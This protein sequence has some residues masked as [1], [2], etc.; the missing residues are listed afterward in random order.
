MRMK[1]DE[2]RFK[3][4]KLKRLN[5]GGIHVEFETKRVEEN[6]TFYDNEKLDS[7]REPHEDFLSKIRA[8]KSYLCE[9]FG[10]T[11][12]KTI[13]KHEDFKATKA[14]IKSAE[15]G[16]QNKIANIEI[17]GFSIHG[18]DDNKNVIIN[19]KFGIQKLGVVALNTPRIKFSNN[20]YG[21][22][23]DLKELVEELSH[24]AY[25]YLYE[26]KREQLKMFGEDEV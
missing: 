19:G 1:V 3:L 11:D 21:W 15:T 13:V 24:E 16:Y 9:I 14:Q 25:L 23:Q 4:Q 5:G 10:F 18:K 17:T 12:L 22:E 8:L 6:E 26:N 7:S 20:L 2:S